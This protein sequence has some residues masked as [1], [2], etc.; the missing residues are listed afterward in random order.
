MKMIKDITIEDKVA[1]LDI[2]NDSIKYE[3]PE[4]V[5]CYDYKGKMY[6]LHSQLVD[7]TVTPNHRNVD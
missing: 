3:H 6:K 7:L 1:V 4:K 2:E 5:H